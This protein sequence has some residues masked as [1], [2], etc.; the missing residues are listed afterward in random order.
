MSRFKIGVMSDSFGLPVREG[1][2]LAAKMGADGVQMYAVSGEMAPEQLTA[3]KIAELRTYIADLGLQISAI[4][5]DMGGH[6]FEIAQDNPARI[7]RSKRIMDNALELGCNVVTT[8][9]GVIPEDAKHPR[10]S[11]LQQACGELAEYADQTGACFAVETGPERA[12]VLKGLLDSLHSKGVGV[13]LDPA[14]LVMVTGDDP[15]AAVETLRDYIVHTHAK[16]GRMIR[17]TDPEIIYGYFA[18][19]G[20]AGF[21]I[22]DYMQEVP[23]G[24]GAVNWKA[25]LNALEQIG[26]QGYLTIERETGADPAADIRMAVQFL[27]GWV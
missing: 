5:A 7:E 23:L 10:W 24:T 11:I 19:H 22:G 2:Q 27:K 17:K 4:C 26:Y 25:Y 18:D 1:L 16:D 13:N 8:H 20:I 14:N 9:I 12:A 3:S 21:Q 6:G 15:V